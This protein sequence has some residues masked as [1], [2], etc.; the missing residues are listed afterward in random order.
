[1]TP[2][3][4]MDV[5]VQHSLNRAVNKPFRYILMKLGAN[6]V[7]TDPTCVD[8]EYDKICNDSNS[9]EVV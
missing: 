8:I 6:V 7:S 2:L 5:Y 9:I 4:R 3:L 1:M